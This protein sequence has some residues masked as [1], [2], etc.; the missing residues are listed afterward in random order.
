[1]VVMSLV[2]S[3]ASY[4]AG[5]LSDRVGRRGLLVAG[6]VVL[7]VADLV[8]AFGGVDRRR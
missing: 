5:V 1:M 7:I 3:L 4:P 2:Y 8:L 6:L